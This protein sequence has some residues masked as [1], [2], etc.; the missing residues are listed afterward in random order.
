MFVGEGN[1]NLE[2]GEH[3]ATVAVGS[4]DQELT[5]IVVD[6]GAFGGQSA[7]YQLTACVCRQ[8]IEAKERRPT[9]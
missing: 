9:Q 5:R 1:S 8:E 6:S 4:I 3:M 7:V 2:A